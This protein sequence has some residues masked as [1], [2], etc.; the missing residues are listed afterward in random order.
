MLT[1]LQ[2]F[3]DLERILS[4]LKTA[5]KVNLLES[6]KMAYAPS[7]LAATLQNYLAQGRCEP[8]CAA[9]HLSWPH[10]YNTRCVANSVVYMPYNS[11]ASWPNTR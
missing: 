5:I 4:R 6:F 1:A 8:R 9:Q 10:P 7:D 11:H 2:S 3:A